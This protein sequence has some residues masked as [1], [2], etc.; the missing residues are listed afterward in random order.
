MEL[1]V[2]TLQVG[3]RY[4]E[5]H[6]KPVIHRQFLSGGLRLWTSRHCHRHTHLALLVQLTL[7]GGENFSVGTNINNAELSISFL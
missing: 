1:D 7:K 4:C 6:H 5:S 2:E 3:E